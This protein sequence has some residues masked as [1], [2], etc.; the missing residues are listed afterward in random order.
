[1]KSLST[2]SAFETPATETRGERRGISVG[3][4]VSLY[5]ISRSTYY[6][7]VEDL[8]REGVVVQVPPVTG[9]PLI[10][11]EPFEAWLKRPRRRRRQ[12]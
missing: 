5:G 2:S 6:R 10:L 11:V 12:A 3:E 7:M 1:V 4:V 8:K 9:R